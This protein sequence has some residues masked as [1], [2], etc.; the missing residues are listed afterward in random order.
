MWAERD[1]L[2]VK[3]FSTRRAIFCCVLFTHCCVPFVQGSRLGHSM[4]SFLIQ[5]ETGMSSV[6]LILS[7][8]FFSVM[9]LQ[10]TGQCLSHCFLY[11][12]CFGKFALFLSRRARPLSVPVLLFFQCQEQ[13]RA[14][15]RPAVHEHTVGCW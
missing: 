14:H 9:I 13:Y 3:V 10:T 1:R 11:I 12:Y 5:R 7:F 15:S 6:S 8:F 4:C 2:L